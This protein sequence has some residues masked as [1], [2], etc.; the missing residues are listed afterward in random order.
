MKRRYQG[1][2]SSSAASTVFALKLPAAPSFNALASMTVARVP[3]RMNVPNKSSRPA[4][5]KNNRPPS[6]VSTA[7]TPALPLPRPSSA[8]I[9]SREPTK[10]KGMRASMR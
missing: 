9:Q 6:G 1:A 7:S 4:V 2:A 5:V 8:S 10:L 3:L